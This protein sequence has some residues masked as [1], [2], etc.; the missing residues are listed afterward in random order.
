MDIL[1]EWLPYG[2][3]NPQI[4]KIISHTNNCI[5]Y[6]G[7]FVYFRHE[8]PLQRIMI[9]YGEPVEDEEGN[10]YSSMISS[11]HVEIYEIVCDEIYE[12]AAEQIT[13][14]Y[15]PIKSNLSEIETKVIADV[16]QENEQNNERKF[17]QSLI[18]EPFN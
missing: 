18:S 5:V 10:I 12:S 11:E 16:I 7:S 6:E 1:Y 9:K 3:K 13:I 8:L 4:C 2:S 15:R 14:K 17:L